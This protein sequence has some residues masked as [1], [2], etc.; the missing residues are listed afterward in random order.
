[1]RVGLAVLGSGVVITPGREGVDGERRVYRRSGERNWKRGW[2]RDN[3]NE[4][5]GGRGGKRETKG[6]MKEGE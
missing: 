5:G 2:K 1:M 3:A 4:G 6:W